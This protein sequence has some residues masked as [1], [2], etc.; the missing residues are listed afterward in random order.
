MG[1]FGILRRE[2][3]FLLSFLCGVHQEIKKKHKQN[4]NKNRESDNQSTQHSIK[5][6]GYFFSVFTKRDRD[7]KEKLVKMTHLLLGHLI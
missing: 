6:R 4:N 7:A 2:C 5:K 1:V 3:F